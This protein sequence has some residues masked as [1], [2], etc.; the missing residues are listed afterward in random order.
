MSEL[1]RADVQMQTSFGLILQYFAA[2]PNAS[3]RALLGLIS[4][5]FLREDSA[6]LADHLSLQMRPQPCTE[7]STCFGD[8]CMSM[9]LP[10]NGAE[11][12]W[13]G[14]SNMQSCHT[15]SECQ[16]QFCTSTR[17]RYRCCRRH[18]HQ[19]PDVRLKLMKS[20]EMVGC[21]DAAAWLFLETFVQSSQIPSWPAIT[22]LAAAQLTGSK[23]DIKLIIA[24]ASPTTDASV[25][26]GLL[27]GHAT[28]T[29]SSSLPSSVPRRSSK[30]HN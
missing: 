12:F 26:L 2:E 16:C 7:P 3:Q 11:T 10:C 20:P 23:L 18:Y 29:L 14:C 8:I 1:G 30:T 4:F 22:T 21:I 13:Y 5:S 24:C 17:T 27:L 28:R 6:E 9:L 15:K 19:V 25:L